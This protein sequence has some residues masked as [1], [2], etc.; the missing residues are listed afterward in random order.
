MGLFSSVLS[1]SVWF[2]IF[3]FSSDTLTCL[4][5]LLIGCT[6]IIYD[7]RSAV[8][9]DRINQPI[10]LPSHPMIDGVKV[11]YN[12]FGL[13]ICA[14][15]VTLNMNLCEYPSTCTV[16]SFSPF[17]ASLVSHFSKKHNKHEFILRLLN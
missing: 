5:F 13:H 7:R 11:D 2:P 16:F 1:I 12:E 6:C 14:Q 4:L 9:S 10:L 17:A 15:S 3:N 8:E